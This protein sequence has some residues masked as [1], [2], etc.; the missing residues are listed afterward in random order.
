MG[1]A[2]SAKKV[3]RLAQ[4]GKAKKV[5]FQGG[6]VFPLVIAIVVVLGVVLIGTSRH[7]S[8]AEAA[9]PTLG[10]HWHLAYGIYVCDHYLEP[11]QNN[12]ESDPNYQYVQI[13][14]HGDGV[15][16]WHPA[17][18]QAINRSTGKAAQF[19]VFLDLYEVDITDSSLKIAGSE[20][21]PAG[22]DIDLQEGKG[23]CD[24]NGKPEKASLRTIVWDRYD[25]PNDRTVHTSNLGHERVLKDQQVF[26]LAWVADSVQNADIPLPKWAT[27]L[28]TLGSNDTNPTTTVAGASGVT[29]STVAGASGVTDS[30][31]AGASGASGVTTTAAAATTLPSTTVAP[32]TTKK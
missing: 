7:Y 9:G 4:R 29:D 19:H 6:S 5:R 10:T 16:H 32:T 17:N 3:A 2:S 8:K 18:E 25:K 14:S 26:V 22:D 15:M 27:D 12:K 1:K 20:L 28:P 31:V 13:H 11:F 23:T 30:T 24:V 21:N